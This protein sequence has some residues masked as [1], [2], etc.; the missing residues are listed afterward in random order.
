VGI[1][2]ERKVQKIS[3]G[4]GGPLVGQN[5]MTRIASKDLSHFQVEEVRDVEG[6][7]FYQIFFLD[8]L[9]LCGV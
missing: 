3:K 4:L 8:L 5:L 2:G 1:A 7:T 9:A 6:L